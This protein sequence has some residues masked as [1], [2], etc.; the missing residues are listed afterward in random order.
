MWPSGYVLV[1]HGN[2]ELGSVFHA[3]RPACRDRLCAGPELNRVR[4]V[5]IQV[6]K[7]R[8]FPPPK[9]MICERDR[10]GNVHANHADIDPAGKIAR[11]IAI[12]CVD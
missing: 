9:R 10:N 6:A 11:R 2:R 8:C 1:H 5:L 4:S 3:G 12:S 7:A